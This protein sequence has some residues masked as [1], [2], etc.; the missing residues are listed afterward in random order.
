MGDP[1]KHH[2][3]TGAPIR[4]VYVSPKTG[5]VFWPIMGGAE[6]AP[7]PAP[8]PKPEPKQPEPKPG[9]GEPAPE[10]E[11]AP[12]FQAKFEAQQKVNRDLERKL[13]EARDAQQSQL[14]TI[15]KALGLKGDEPPDPAKLTEQVTKEQQNA[16]DAQVQLAV[17]RNA[18]DAGGDP[19][20]LLDSASFLRSL[21]NVDPADAEAVA[22]AVKEAVAA[23]A[24]LG[25]TDDGKPRSPRPDPTQGRTSGKPLDPR[26]ADLAQI[27]SDL[28]AARR[29]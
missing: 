29:R 10:P 2:P 9:Q 3:L 27:E 6:P 17:Y 22:T 19:D 26:S 15:A 23:N 24:R 28:A 20:A 8:E 12:D 7:E 16:R 14:D 1:A 21:A 13:N 11:P 4:P 5:R 25:A 18:K